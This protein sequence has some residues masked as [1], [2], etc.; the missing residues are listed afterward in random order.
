[1][2]STF[3]KG[4]LFCSWFPTEYKKPLHYH[5]NYKHLL[6][7]ITNGSLHQVTDKS[8]DWNGFST[9]KRS[10]TNGDPTLTGFLE[11][12]VPASK[13]IA[14]IQSMTASSIFV[15]LQQLLLLFAK[16]KRNAK[17]PQKVGTQ[18]QGK[19]PREKIAYF[20]PAVTSMLIPDHLWRRV[21]RRRLVPTQACFLQAQWRS[22]TSDW[23]KQEGKGHSQW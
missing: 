14:M 13:G 5:T 15:T 21:S 7:D 16:S 22:W 20:S 12:T 23:K 1:M 19:V 2:F 17:L 3:Q 11:I 10:L 8:T 6:N 18:R 4:L 9:A